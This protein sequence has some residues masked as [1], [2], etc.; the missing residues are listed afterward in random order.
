M[1][2]GASYRWTARAARSTSKLFIRYL[3]VSG[4][5]PTLHPDLDAI[6]RHAQ[7][8]HMAVVLV[9]NGSRLTPQRCGALAAAGVSSMVISIDA[10]TAEA[11]EK[12]RRLKNVCRRIRVAN[13][14]LASLGVQ[15]T[16]S[17]RWRRF[18]GS[19][20]SPP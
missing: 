10:A 9:S 19:W 13:E 8:R 16:A 3:I 12:N 20:D 6:I 2:I 5:E 7:R 1:P 17:G 15:S 11:H 14:T 18:S 4:G